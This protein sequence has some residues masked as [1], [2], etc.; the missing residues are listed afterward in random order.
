MSEL[1]PNAIKTIGDVLPEE[2]TRVQGIIAMYKSVQNG[3]FAAALM[4]QDIDA[5]YK[6]MMEGDLA[7]MIAAYQEL[8]EWENE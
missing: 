7:G 3:Q 1:N 6:A 5:A 4:Q 8:K 2:I